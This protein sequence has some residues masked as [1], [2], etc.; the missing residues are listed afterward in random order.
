MEESD[1]RLADGPA[2]IDVRLAPGR[3]KLGADARASDAEGFDGD[4]CAIVGT[5]VERG[6]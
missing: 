3:L 6:G 2:G 1:K 4:G 5:D